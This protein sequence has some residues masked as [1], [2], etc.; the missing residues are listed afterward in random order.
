MLLLSGV[1]GTREDISI[2]QH[3]EKQAAFLHAVSSISAE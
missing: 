3:E 2:V 1:I